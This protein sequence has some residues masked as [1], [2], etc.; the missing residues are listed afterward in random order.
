MTYKFTNCQD[1]EVLFGQPFQLGAKVCV[2]VLCDNLWAYFLGAHVYISKL[3]CCFLSIFQEVE[4]NDLV[5]AEHVVNHWQILKIKLILPLF[6]I[7][8]IIHIYALLF[9]R[10][11]LIESAGLQTLLNTISVDFTY[12]IPRCLA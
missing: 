8:E 9:Q 6:F 5:V 3:H 11:Q 1:A 7:G 2:F 12:R 10:K 4:S